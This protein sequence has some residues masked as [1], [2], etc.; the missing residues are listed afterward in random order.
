MLGDDFEGMTLHHVVEEEKLDT[1]GPVRLAYDQ[2]L[3]QE[4]LFVMNGD[5][6]ADLDLSARAARTTRRRGAACTLGLVARRRHVGLRRRAHARR[7]PG[8]GV[9][10][11]AVR[12]RA[13]EPH[14]RGRLR[15]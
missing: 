10:R 12:P 3:L 13:D 6:L 5:C 9:P 4:R 15:A 11:E 8:R 1:A 14:Q 2:G 7:R